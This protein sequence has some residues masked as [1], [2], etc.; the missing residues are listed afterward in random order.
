M[1]ALLLAHDFPPVLSGG[2]AQYYH[3][4]S[5]A[6]PEVLTVLAPDG[7]GCR[8]FDSGQPFRVERR[9]MPLVPISFMTS[10]RPN[11][12]R[13][14]RLIYIAVVQWWSYY[15]HA[16]RVLKRD[17]ADIVLVGHLYLGPLG[18]RLRRAAGIPF[19]IMLHGS[20]LHRYATVGAVQRRVRRTLNAADF[21]VVNSDFTRRQYLERGVRSDQRF[22]TLNPGVDT[23]RFRPDAGEPAAVRARFDLGQRPVLLSV[24]RL[25][26][27]KGHDVVLR[28]LPR[29]VERIPDL[30]YLIVG[31]GPFRSELERLVSELGVREHVVFAG[32]VPEPELPSFYRVAR[33]MV[34]PS[35][36]FRERLPVEGFGIVYVEAA[37]CGVPVIG[38]RGGGTG[39][40]I[41]DGVTGLRVDPHDVD[42]VADAA[43]KLLTD[44]SL[45]AR[46]AAAAVEHG[47]RF[48]WQRQA[49]R[50]REFLREVVNGG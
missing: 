18:P 6:L 40:S 30:V 16:V 26:E 19:G 1:R 48:D 41:V 13:W 5:R 22:L 32:F 24:A 44:D 15:R 28:G 25:V 7:P 3:Q 49:E 35:R 50:L 10:G 20:E 21:L 31:D 39:E 45:H 23:R 33:A 12:L 8:E 9:H 37:A 43:L 36:E 4:L 34:I 47:L 29:L 27:W 17:G 11:L 2:I 38:G 14:P 42:S 46:M